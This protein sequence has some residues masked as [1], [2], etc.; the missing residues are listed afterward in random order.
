LKWFSL[1]AEQG[2]LASG[3]NIG[4]IYKHGGYGVPKDVNAAFPWLKKFGIAMCFYK[5]SD[6]AKD[7]AAARDWSEKS[8]DQGFEHAQTM[9]GTMMAKGEGGE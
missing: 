9:L 2:C 8:A 5:G 3:R 7:L 6:T 4:Y 1:A